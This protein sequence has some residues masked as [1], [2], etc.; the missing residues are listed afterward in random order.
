MSC[1]CGLSDKVEDHGSETFCIACGSIVKQDFLVEDKP[2]FWDKFQH[3]RHDFTKDPANKF[4]THGIFG[5]SKETYN[6]RQKTL[7]KRNLMISCHQ[8]KLPH[9]E[10]IAETALSMLEKHIFK[11]RKHMLQKHRAAAIYTSCKLHN[12]E[13]TSSEII[14]SLQVT[15]KHLSTFF[16]K[17]YRMCTSNHDQLNT[18]L[19]QSQPIHLAD[20][21]DLEMNGVIPPDSSRTFL[22]YCSDLS[23]L[24]PVPPEPRRHTSYGKHSGYFLR[25]SRHRLVVFANMVSQYLYGEELGSSKFEAAG[26]KDC[27]IVSF[28]KDTDLCWSILH[29]TCALFMKWLLW[30]CSPVSDRKSQ[31]FRRKTFPKLLGK[32]LE[33][34]GLLLE[35]LRKYRE[36][37]SV[38]VARAKQKSCQKRR[39]KSISC[40]KN[41][42]KTTSLSSTSSLSQSTGSSMEEECTAINT[43]TLNQC[44]EV[45]NKYIVLHHPDQIVQQFERLL[46]ILYLTDMKPLLQRIPKLI[47]FVL[48][49][50]I[51]STVEPSVPSLSQLQNQKNKTEKIDEAIRKTFIR[52]FIKYSATMLPTN[53]DKEKL[54]ETIHTYYYTIV[55]SVKTYRKLINTI[56]LDTTSEP[57]PVSSSVSSPRSD[58][59]FVVP[60]EFTNALQSGY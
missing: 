60:A 37:G 18:E 52:I 54:T 48:L 56:S 1:A 9:P 43:N 47:Y 39:R 30:N 14:D 15:G 3:Q 24:F 33:R 59:Q 23:E 41:S 45:L 32:L 16:L 28:Q 57:S 29:K 27:R 25:D 22:K 50:Q 19:S 58:I 44:L 40:T 34:K 51:I 38:K 26:V 20:I 11:P 49:H 4:V 5:S 8:L 17:F 12:I 6:I 53:L 2:N 7:K 46:A 31:V 21:K 36:F 35:N 55:G 13:I 42:P 10:L